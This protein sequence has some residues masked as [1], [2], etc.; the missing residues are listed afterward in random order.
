[1]N[2]VPLQ[3]VYLFFVLM[4]LPAWIFL[5]LLCKEYRG[6]MLAFGLFNAAAGFAFEWFIWT[7][8]WVHSLTLS[9]T[10]AGI[11]DLLLGFLLAGISFGL[12]KKG[13]FL[14]GR[15]APHYKK[16]SG[17]YIKIWLGEALCL[18]SAWT[19]CRLVPTRHSFDAS[20][21]GI[22]IVLVV[23]FFIRHDL[24]VDSVLAGLG[25][26]MISIPAYL[27]AFSA[28]SQ[29]AQ[30]YWQWQNLSGFTLLGIPGE[31]LIW[32]FFTGAFLAPLYEFWHDFYFGKRD[33]S[34]KAACA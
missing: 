22:G 9:R 27:A 34:E 1:M 14:R 4:F 15:K 2:A 23:L 24:I 31:D 11:E 8:D 19:V 33:S 28:H 21:I 7:K 29:F 18:L 26:A 32:F 30:K 12:F 10:P 13:L 6:E 16:G 17:V 25:L 5:F 3:F 20:V